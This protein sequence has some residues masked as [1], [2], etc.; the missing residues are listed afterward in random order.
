MSIQQ[1]IEWRSKALYNKFWD[2][3][4][5]NPQWLRHILQNNP[6]LF[7]LLI[8]S[9]KND[10]DSF[11]DLVQRLRTLARQEAQERATNQVN[12]GLNTEQIA[13]TLKYQ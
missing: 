2:E 8:D 4:V 5:D 11:T 1:V 7:A 3:L 13:E 12:A 9:L 6:E 10:T